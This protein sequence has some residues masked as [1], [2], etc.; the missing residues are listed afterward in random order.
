MIVYRYNFGA[1]KIPVSDERPVG[2]GATIVL[3]EYVP[4]AMCTPVPSPNLKVELKVKTAGRWI[5]LR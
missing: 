5:E 4:A 3:C 2:I 1:H